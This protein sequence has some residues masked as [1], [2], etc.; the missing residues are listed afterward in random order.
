MAFIKEVIQTDEQKAFFE[1]F[2]FRDYR[3][4][5]LEVGRWYVDKPNKLY[6]FAMG[7]GSFEIPYMYG[8]MT[9]Q[10]LIVIERHTPNKFVKSEEN[11]NVFFVHWSVD[12]ISY[13]PN[14]QYTCDKITALVTDAITCS[15]IADST[16]AKKYIAVMDRMAIPQIYTEWEE[17]HYAMNN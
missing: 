14:M 13:P 16:N 11:E 3:G 7:G 8:L 17:T 15:E 1:S 5:K 9:P 12:K 6:F 10:G 4:K 2:G